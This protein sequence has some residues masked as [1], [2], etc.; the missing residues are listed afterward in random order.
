MRILLRL[1]LAVLLLT[2]VLETRILGLEG[3]V[4]TFSGKDYQGKIR[5]EP[6]DLVIVNSGT[7]L[8]AHVK[9]QDISH[10][11]LDQPEP[12]ALETNSDA[13][14]EE[15]KLD[16]PF[17][18][19][20]ADIG[21]PPGIVA[22]SYRDGLF[23]I[24]SRSAAL[25]QGAD[26]ARFIFERIR[27]DREIV[28][29]VIRCTPTHAHARAGLMFRASLNETSESIFLGATAGDGDVCE[30]RS[31]NGGGMDVLAS[32]S[33][34]G[35]R[36][37]KLKRQGDLF[38]AYRSKDGLRWMLLCETNLVF[39]KDLLVGLTGAGI[40]ELPT[41]AAVFEH[42]RHQQRMPSPFPIRTEL[43]SGSSVESVGM[44]LEGSEVRFYGLHT[45]PAV[46]RDHVARILFQPV[47]GRMEARLRIGQPGVLLTSGEFIEG[48]VRSLLDGTLLLDSVL[49]GQRRFDAA[50]QII[51]AVLA[52]QTRIPAAHEIR[53][54]DGSFWRVNSMD[55]E[56]LYLRVTEP[57]LGA[58]R[59][60]LSDLA[61][62][63]VER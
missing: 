57:V 36:W 7:G 33:Q 11:W 12:L 47:P 39:P 50:N 8:W 13:T 21:S 27:G 46:K 37:F 53:M 16:L 62:I 31:T 49:I 26:A 20:F 23:R 9:V 28:A 43:V 61:S 41:H 54:V 51:G 5:W 58:C 17:P 44:E 42:V 14:P 15:A 34:P 35:M 52:P 6:E 4:R 56:S 22:H 30:W 40:V 63:E 1:I 55:L 32:P 29:R 10:L 2:Q 60:P 24:D 18:W 19:E 3:R 45:I 48:Q 59:L 38:S 25:G